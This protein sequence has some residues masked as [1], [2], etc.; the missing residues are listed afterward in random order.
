MEIDDRA[1]EARLQ[2]LDLL[3]TVSVFGRAFYR[4]IAHL[5][6][7]IETER[8]VRVALAGMLD[9]ELRYHREL[10]RLAEREQVKAEELQGTT[11]RHRIGLYAVCEYTRQVTRR[12][13][14]AEAACDL[15]LAEC[16]YHLRRTTEVVAALERVVSTGLNQPLVHFALGYNRYLLALETCAQAGTGEG[17]FV[18]ADPVAFRV[19]CLRAV[20]ALED[21]L[22][23][24]ALDG[25]LYWWIGI[26]LEAAG[27]TEAA[28]D[29]Y[30]KSAKL[31][32]PEQ[33]RDAQAP[34]EVEAWR[35][36]DSVSQGISDEEVKEAG[37]LLAGPF[38]PSWL[39]DAEQDNR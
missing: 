3:E 16:S 4:L 2:E 29:A 14:L 10:Q 32:H 26:I 5:V 24:T 11:E 1:I 9:V 27:L 12:E 17:E 36:Q 28:Q 21:G 30:D 35:P 25:Q 7:M 19:Q 18:V 22:Q 23:G 31:L 37:R 20:S 8:G 33:P 15:I 13:V 34:G 39:L 6:G 38:D